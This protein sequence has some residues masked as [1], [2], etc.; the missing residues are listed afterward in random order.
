MKSSRRTPPRSGRRFLVR[1]DRAL[2]RPA[3]T[4]LANAL[5]E[6]GV[7]AF[8]LHPNLVVREVFRNADCPLPALVSR[9]GLPGESRSVG[10]AAGCPTVEPA[11][12]GRGHEA[13]QF[14]G[15]G[16][17]D[18][19]RLGLPIILGRRR[20]RG[21]SSKACRQY[22]AEHRAC[23]GRAS[24]I[25]SI[26]VHVHPHPA[27]NITHSIAPR[28]YPLVRSIGLFSGIWGRCGSGQ[29]FR[30]GDLTITYARVYCR[31]QSGGRQ[32]S[33]AGA[34]AANLARGRS[35]AQP[36][37]TEHPTFCPVAASRTSFASS[38]FNPTRLAL[39][40]LLAR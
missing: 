17:A 35:V 9:N 16:Q 40:S 27:D 20:G 18:G 6:H 36:T 30:T 25:F 13:L 14:H 7:K 21:A 37:Q 11:V 38:R 24:I 33:P 19:G 1:P 23:F 22:R 3:A 15:L 10:M 12:Y 39:T 34:C 4:G 5:P 26:V 32:A 29:S 8:S 31:K 2:D 28:K